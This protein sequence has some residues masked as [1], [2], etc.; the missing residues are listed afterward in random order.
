[1]EEPISHVNAATMNDHRDLVP[2]GSFRFH[3]GA[4]RGGAAQLIW[5]GW[6]RHAPLSRTANQLERYIR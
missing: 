5:N 1:M 2:E 4:R 6:I 3:Y